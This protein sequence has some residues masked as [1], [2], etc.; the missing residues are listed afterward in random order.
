MSC[1]YRNTRRMKHFFFTLFCVK[2]DKYVYTNVGGRTMKINEGVRLHQIKTTKFKDIALS[3][4]FQNALEKKTAC[5]RSLL[6][7]MLCDRSQKFDTKKKMSDQQDALYGATL[8][9]QTAGFGAS[10]IIDIRSKV[11]NPRFVNDGE[12]M[13]KEWV[14]FMKEILF[15]PLLT[16]ESFEES[17]HILLSKIERMMDDPGQYVI[18]RGLKLA[19]KQIPLGISALG[20]KQDV[21]ALTLKDIEM[22]YEQMISEDAIDIILC[23]DFD[24]QMKKSIVNELTFEAR[25]GKFTSHYVA[26]NEEQETQSE[27]YK[28]IS[29]SSIMMTWFS[30]IDV[31]DA[32]YYPLR[33]ANAMFGQYS[34]SLLFQEVRE[35][36]SLCYSIFS[37]LISY[38]AAM[39]VTTGIEKENIDKTIALIKEQF[40]RLKEGTFDDQ[41]L[42]VSKTMIVNSL[43]A[44]KDS[45]NS[46]IA[47]AYQNRLLEE[48]ATTQ[49][50]IAK[51]EA[52]TKEDVMRAMNRCELKHTFI[53]TKEDTNEDNHE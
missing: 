15:Q 37:N 6:A 40:N 33:V 27:E 46:L 17:K 34:T 39:G 22:A 30:N 1:G 14:L 23:G 43:K 11:V 18:S 52:V 16:Q 53:L 2:I 19:G 32:D 48:E 42:N 4:R 9:A 26:S 24:E 28:N 3:I 21:E 50:I 41:L 38:D 51:V 25:P 36:N 8:H 49:D 10:Q 47:L 5:A 13:M 29:Q 35:K 44:S 45:M 31:L 12:E 20:E 7:L